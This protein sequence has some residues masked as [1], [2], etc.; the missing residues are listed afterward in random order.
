MDEQPPLTAL[1]VDD[2]AIARQMLT[3]ILTRDAWEVTAVSGGAQALEALRARSFD[4]VLTDLVMDEVDG[5]AVLSAAKQQDPSVQVILMTGHA[6]AD[7]AIAAM[8]GGA[9]HYVQKPIRPDEVR[10]LMKEAGDKRRLSVRVERL[11]A[12]LCKGAVCRIVGTSPPID[13]VRKLIARIRQSDSNVLITGESGTGKELVARAIHECSRRFGQPFV[14]FNCGAFSDDLVANELFGHEKDAFT[15][16]TTARKGLLEVSTG[17]TV[18]F[19]EVGDMSLGMQAKLLRAVQEREIMRVGGTRPIPIDI[20]I[21]AATNK[22]LKKLISLGAFRE[23]LF[24]RLNVIPVRM[25]S[26]AE[27][28]EDIPLLASHFLAQARSRMGKDLTGFSPEA[29]DVLAGYRYPGNVRELENIVE[30]AASL[31]V[32]SRIEI[33]DLPPDLTQLELRTFRYEGGEMKSL[34]E[35]E[36]QYIRWVLERVGNNKSRAAQVLGIDRV[37]LYRKLRRREVSG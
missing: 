29:L 11:E 2:E 28:R 19:D 20:R 9:F 5:L 10:M 33:E 4:V 18:F 27:R 30:R 35:L 32:G 14:A 34:D 31:A 1:V 37:S 15:G 3:R 6:S 36:A 25:P 23:D 13:E 7:S 24:Y 22:D 8:K 16:A 12:H 17:G 21:I 26:L